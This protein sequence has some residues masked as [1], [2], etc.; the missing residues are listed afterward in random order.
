[1]FLSGLVQDTE[2]I[3]FEFSIETISSKDT[4]RDFRIILFYNDEFVNA[5]TNISDY[6]YSKDIRFSFLSVSKLFVP[7]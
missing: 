2:R 3:N 1:M 4:I 5:F 7:R 6:Y